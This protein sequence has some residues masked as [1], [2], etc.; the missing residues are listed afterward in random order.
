M[1]FARPERLLAST[2][3]RMAVV[4]A[5]LLVAAFSLAGIAAWFATRTAAEQQIRERVELEMSALQQEL[6]IEGLPAVIAAIETRSES[7]GALEYRLFDADGNVLIGDL[8]VTLPSLG[9]SFLDVADSE[10]L[11]EGEEDLLVFAQPTQNG[12]VLVIADDLLHAERVRAS[13]LSSIF[14]VGGL[15]L[16]L[17]LGAGA[18]A[19]RGALRRVDALSATLALAGA[20]ELSVR[21]PER[22]GG[23][24]I[25]AI[26]R[27][28]NAMLARIDALV[29]NVRRVST[30]VA[31]DL[32]TPLTHVRQH[33]EAAAAAR[34]PDAASVA[35]QNAQNKID[36]IL[37]TFAAIL[38]LAEIEAGAARSRFA[39]LELSSLVERVTDA[40]RPDMEANGQ[41]VRFEAGEGITIVGDGDLIAQAIGNLLENAMR[42]AGGEA[43]IVVRLRGGDRARLEVEDNGVGVAAGERARVVEPFV[44][45]DSTR[46]SSGAGLGLSIVAAIAKLHDAEFGLEDA[47]PGLRAVLTWR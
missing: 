38:R 22:A 34:D 32:R 9:W 6:Q 8:P 45:L 17:A 42:Y 20:G 10:A 27:G 47:N 13:V 11:K 44:R 23:D 41:S 40:Y 43:G 2:S 12:G 14:W 7:P 28:V 4:Y 25:D 1:S 21:A 16:L 37:R 29:A 24:D 5:L 39:P 18:I 3:A 19:A 46:S 35:I 26:A 36:E 31:H 30:D 33:L 15:A